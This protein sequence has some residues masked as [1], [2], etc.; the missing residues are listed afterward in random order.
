MRREKSSRERFGFAAVIISVALLISVSVMPGLPAANGEESATQ[1]KVL[2]VVTTVSILRDF[3]LEI[4]KERVTCI[5][6]VSGT[7]NPHTYATT[8]A[9]RTAIEEAS[10]FV[11][12]GGDAGPE[13]EPWAQDLLDSSDNNDL[14]VCEAAS[15][16]PLKENNPH[17]WMDPENAKIMVINIEKALIEADPTNSEL[18]RSNTAAYLQRI[19]T[20]E[21]KILEEMAP[22]N[23]TKV[24]ASH[25]AFLY[26]FDFI[27]FKQVDL[28]IEVPGQSPSAQHVSRI[29]DEIKEQNVSLIV[30][31]P[32]F[33]TPVIEQ[34][35]QDTDVKAVE[36][37]P[38][39]G[40]LNTTTY[41]GLLEY[42]TQAII[43]AL[44]NSSGAGESQSDGAQLIVYAS[45]FGGIIAGAAVIV[46]IYRRKRSG[47]E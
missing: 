2:D 42:D 24:I 41:L 43:G 30:T 3:V 21:A 14:I 8:T 5:S 39:I 19:N 27:G 46:W 11:E 16:I 9:D 23:G 44:S 12:F 31:M 38:L 32:Q 7:E 1:A 34:I 20:T 26:F 17:V 36:I 33:P 47:E 15:G 13:L 29:I 37:T 4:G 28:L 25:P 6:L 22:Y 35:Q 18:Y 45:A 40:P 10:A